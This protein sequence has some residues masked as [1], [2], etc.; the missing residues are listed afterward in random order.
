MK[1]FK[2][3]FSEN[4]KTYR[5]DNNLS[6]EIAAENMGISTVFLSEL[7]CCKKTPSAET[8]IRLYRYMGYDYIPISP[9][10]GDDAYR[11]LLSILSKNPEISETL[12]SV[13]KNLIK[14]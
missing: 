6:Q 8:L 13:A 4:L 10:S 3:N 1:E 12:L 9:A 11:E 2:I 7:E 5:R 14:E